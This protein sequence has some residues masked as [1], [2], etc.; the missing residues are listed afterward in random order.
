ML[1]WAPCAFLWA[2]AI[3]D[4]FYMRS[5][6]NR[7]VPWGVLNLTKVG[8]TA[9]LIVLTLADLGLAAGRPAADVFAVD[10]WTPAIKVMSFVSV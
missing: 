7:N 3:L 2:L 1:V 10:F 9:A 8:V 5:A 6:M 4:V